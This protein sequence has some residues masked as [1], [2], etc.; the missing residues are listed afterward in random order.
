MNEYSFIHSYDHHRYIC[1]YEKTR[2]LTLVA[3]YV[4][5][6]LTSPYICKFAAYICVKINKRSQTLLPSI[7]SRK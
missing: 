3:Q 2:C 7:I 6:D 4:I 5:C 1:L